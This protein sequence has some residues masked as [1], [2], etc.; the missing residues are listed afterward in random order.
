MWNLEK[1]SLG[2][3]NY[4]NMFGKVFIIFLSSFA[5]LN[6]Q[7]CPDLTGTAAVNCVLV[8]GCNNLNGTLTA[9]AT[10]CSN[11]LSDSDCQTLFPCPAP[12][13]TPALA[14]ITN[15]CITKATAAGTDPLNPVNFPWVRAPACV[16][17]DLQNV[18]LQ[19]EFCK[20][21]N[22]LN[23]RSSTKFCRFFG[24]ASI[25]LINRCINQ[26]LL[27]VLHYIVKYHVL[28]HL[29]ALLIFY[30]LIS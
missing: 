23:I 30:S 25:F 12:A 4:P 7:R 18:A 16:S 11:Q 5:L 9:L 6:G 21:L 17:P 2:I 20:L 10:Q 22:N 26:Q 1:T 14:G 29:F 24:R 15:G 3:E 19:C 27:P 28:L 13:P 8:P